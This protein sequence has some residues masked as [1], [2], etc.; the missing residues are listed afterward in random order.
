M[1]CG[2]TMPSTSMCSRRCQLRTAS[3]R[4]PAEDAEVPGLPVQKRVVVS[5]HQAAQR[6]WPEPI[7]KRR[8]LRGHLPGSFAWRVID[9]EAQF[10]GQEGNEFRVSWWGS[11]G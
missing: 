1:V 5:H 6:L 10:T 2:P 9:D 8:K 4:S 3:R 11:P 7:H